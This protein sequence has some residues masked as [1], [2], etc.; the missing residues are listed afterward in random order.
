MHKYDKKSTSHTETMVLRQTICSATNLQ[1]LGNG[2][3]VSSVP[4][5]AAVG[6]IS[7]IVAEEHCAVLEGTNG[8]YFTSQFKTTVLPIYY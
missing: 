8:S 2:V 6:T 4:T 3:A 5:A 1:K 7:A